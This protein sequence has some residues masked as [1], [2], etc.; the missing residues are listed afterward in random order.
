K[1]YELDQKVKLSPNDEVILA[2]KAFD[3]GN[4]VRVFDCETLIA[5]PERLKNASYM[6]VIRAVFGTDSLNVSDYSET[7][8]PVEVLSLEDVITLSQKGYDLT[9]SDFEKY[10]YI[11]TGSGLYIRVYEINEMFELWIG[12][13]GPD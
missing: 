5:E 3:T 13:S 8:S 6:I 10:D 2:A 11:E 9:W 1:G 7:Y 4:G 12:G